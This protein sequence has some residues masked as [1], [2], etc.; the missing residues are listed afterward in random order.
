MP[1][2]TEGELCIAGDGLA[3]GYLN[4]PELTADRFIELD[5]FDKTELVYKT[6]DLTRWTPEG[7]LEYLGRL[8]HQIKLRGL[9]IEPSEIEAV[10]REHKVVTE[11]VVVLQGTADNPTL[12]AY[13]TIATDDDTTL[14]PHLRDWLT[15]RLPAYMV[16]GSFTQLDTLPLTPRMAR[17]TVRPCQNLIH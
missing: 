7:C 11:A 15:T 10:L 16:L 6:G 13:V 8:D 14:I 12:A 17:L 5:L 4:Q 1:I 2:G 9:R 3:C